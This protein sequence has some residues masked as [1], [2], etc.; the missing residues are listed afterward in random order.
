MFD[1]CFACRAVSNGSLTRA[2]IRR[3]R[4]EKRDALPSK[5]VIH[6]PQRLGVRAEARELVDNAVDRKYET[7]GFYLG[8]RRRIAPLVRRA[9]YGPPSVATNGA[10]QVCDIV[11]A[12]CVRAR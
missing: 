10:E 7:R 12:Y 5:D 4:G 3:A 6:R 11:A 1:V 9:A 2:R 8:D